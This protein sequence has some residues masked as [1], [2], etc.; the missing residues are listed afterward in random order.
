MPILEGKEASAVQL[1]ELEPVRHYNLGELEEVYMKQIGRFVKDPHVVGNLNR[2]LYDNPAFEG[3]MGTFDYTSLE[4]LR[5]ILETLQKQQFQNAL[6]KSLSDKRFEAEM[7]VD[8]YTAEHHTLFRDEN[9]IWWRGGKQDLN[10]PYDGPMWEDDWMRKAIARQDEGIAPK[11]GPVDGLGARDKWGQ[12]GRDS[13]QPASREIHEEVMLEPENYEQPSVAYDVKPG[14]MNMNEAPIVT[15]QEENYYRVMQNMR[16][17]HDV[18]VADNFAFDEFGFGKTVDQET[19]RKIM[20]PQK[21]DMG[22]EDLVDLNEISTEVPEVNIELQEIRLGMLPDADILEQNN[23]ILL[24]APRMA[25]ED[26]AEDIVAEVE[27]AGEVAARGWRVMA[28]F[29][30]YGAWINPVVGT[31]FAI[32]YG[33][34]QLVSSSHKANDGRQDKAPEVT[35]IGFLYDRFAGTDHI[36]LPCYVALEPKKKSWVVFFLDLWQYPR[37][38]EVHKDRVILL[39]KATG[40]KNPNVTYNDEGYPVYTSPDSMQDFLPL[41]KDADGKWV[42]TTYKQKYAKGDIVVYDGKIHRISRGYLYHKVYKFQDD[43]YMLDGVEEPVHPSLLTPYM[44]EDKPPPLPPKLVN[45]FDYEDPWFKENYMGYFFDG[46]KGHF[47]MRENDINV[48]GRNWQNDPLW[49]ASSNMYESM[50]D[51]GYW[52][53]S[54]TTYG[55]R[56]DN[57]RRII[58]PKLF[59]S[60]K[61]YQNKRMPE[62]ITKKNS[63]K[64]RLKAKMKAHDA[65]PSAQ[66]SFQ[67]PIEEE[68]DDFA[69]LRETPAEPPKNVEKS[70][71]VFKGRQ[72]PT[73][74]QKNTAKERLKAKMKKHSIGE[75]S[76]Q[77]SFEIPDEKEPD[78]FA[79][80]KKETEIKEPARPTS[81]TFGQWV[82]EKIVYQ[83]AWAFPYEKTEAP[84]APPSPT[85][86][87]Q[88]FNSRRLMS[89]IYEEESEA[90]SEES[91]I[92]KHIRNMESAYEE[93]RVSGRTSRLERIKKPQDNTFM[94]LV[95]VGALACLV[96]LSQNQK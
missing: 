51:A 9:N 89:K 11:Y 30:E 17:L 31:L 5:E 91:Y 72:R 56:I 69:W 85:R 42:S 45:P 6:K 61:V 25:Q 63:A 87:N 41:I 76:A 32:G 65:G 47:Q 57:L 80:L 29:Q 70:G 75:P 2:A 26:L 95:G 54:T 71:K 92:T 34:W 44:S 14:E 68:P 74:T 16:E 77:E 66:E 22:M 23:R 82:P 79:T 33:I 21:T 3:R 84:P 67:I 10:K 36:A 43:H 7:N 18:R 93:G 19:A 96:F 1:T 13:W 50:L 94:I 83:D 12:L 24:A 35:R 62:H 39:E 73:V 49:E 52:G 58:A 86:D 38:L 15:E 59:K 20:A 28:F 88:G 81:P 46:M 8:Y 53:K 37:N 48:G 90:E 4:D 60:G 27:E 55:E 40:T 78:D 64:E